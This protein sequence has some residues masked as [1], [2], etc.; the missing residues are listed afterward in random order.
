MKNKNK[1]NNIV[2]G[3]KL[4]NKLCCVHCGEC[5]GVRV[6]VLLTRMEKF[7]GS[8]KGRLDALLKS[9]V[10]RSCRKEK[11]VDGTG[12][13]VTAASGIKIDLSDAFWRQPGYS[14]DNGSKK[15]NADAIQNLTSHTC[16]FPNLNL[17]YRC[18]ECS[19]LSNCMFEKKRMSMGTKK[20]SKGKRARHH[21][22]AK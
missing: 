8:V 7:S 21:R 19:C 9:Y 20:E 3:V 4:P 17:G 6:D 22:K 18:D 1:P 2:D 13:P 11:G 5:K 10:C 12:E 15:L 16:L 14:F